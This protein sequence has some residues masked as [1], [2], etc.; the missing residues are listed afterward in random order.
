MSDPGSLIALRTSLTG[1]LTIN[2][3]QR[4]S[5]WGDPRAMTLA[6]KTVK[7]A[8]GGGDDAERPPNATLV[9]AVRSFFRSRQIASFA[10]LKYVCYGVAV[11]VDADGKRLIDRAPLLDE[12]FRLVDGR[13]NQSKQYRRCYQGLMTGYFAFD[14]SSAD[15]APS[16]ANWQKLRGFLGDRLQRVAAAARQRGRQPEWLETLAE[17]RNLLGDEPCTRYAQALRRGDRSELAQVC[18]GLGIESDS[19]VWHEAVMAYVHEVVRSEER[20]FQR[21][22]PQVL[23]VVD[24]KH[25]DLKLPVPVARDAAALVVVRYQKCHDKPE[26]PDLR[27]ICLRLIGNPWLS[28]AAW[29]ASV[30]SEPARKMIESWLKRRL[31]RDFFELLAHDGAADVRRL[32]YWLKWEPHITDMWFVLGVD[33]RA[34]RS[35]ASEALKER[36]KGRSRRLMGTTPTANNAFI[37]R[38]GTKLV[39]EFGLTNNACF[40]FPAADSSLDLERMDLDIYDLKHQP[41][42]KQLNHMSQWEA[43]FDRHLSSLLNT[44][45]SKST[46]NLASPLRAN[47]PPARRAGAPLSATSDAGWAIASVLERNAAWPWKPAAEGKVATPGIASTAAAG[48]RGTGRKEL[49]KGDL[50]DLQD[51]CDQQGIRLIDNRAKGGAL[52]VRVDGVRPSG[53]LVEA[54]DRFGFRYSSGRGYYLEAD[55]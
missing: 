29:D 27:D 51:L 34:N 31:I 36:M 24:G 48:S 6:L 28:R 12:L 19:W 26:H 10:E 15:A 9:S 14:H 7:Q 33:A 54:I 47:A 13:Q 21:E 37:M 40:V 38:I 41:G 42:R 44:N 16:V 39:V 45:V 18:A 22:M 2:R 4:E 55:D 50:E 46:E 11:P 23:E 5:G 52:W 30:R 49:S 43:T 3:T 32:N 25:D 53:R 20:Q 8:F 1:A 17:H 35:A